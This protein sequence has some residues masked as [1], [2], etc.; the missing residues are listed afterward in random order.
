MYRL[1]KADA[2]TEKTEKTPRVGAPPPF[3]GGRL[4]VTDAAGKRTV[5][6]GVEIT[7]Y[8]EE[9]LEAR[10]C[11]ARERVASWAENARR[12]A[13]EGRERERDREPSRARPEK[14][15]EDDR[16]PRFSREATET[17]S[18]T[19]STVTETETEPAMR[20][21]NEPTASEPV[22][23]FE[24]KRLEAS[25]ADDEPPF[26]FVGGFVGYLGYETRAECGSFR[27]E[28]D[29]PTPDAAFFFADRFVVADHLTGDAFVAAL[30]DDPSAALRAHVEPLAENENRNGLASA[31]RAAAEGVLRV[32][33]DDAE[34]AARAWMAETE[35]AVL[36]CADIKNK[37]DTENM[38]L[39]RMLLRWS[40]VSRRMPSGARAIASAP[41][42]RRAGR[43]PPVRAARRP[44]RVRARHRRVA[45]FHRRGGDLRGVFDE[46]AGSRRTNEERGGGTKK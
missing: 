32:A 13:R 36:A 25:L 35:R 38:G 14:D 39:Q 37:N 3:T 5:S 21:T 30:T 31:A 46:P 8:L 20:T 2:K 22:E 9:A 24:R 16:S 12:R 17:E 26:D 27:S 7:A 44:R 10:R 41:S 40:R 33:A 11:G 28:N 6:E 43:P 23:D 34:A 29:A 4:E 18:V 19:E 45:G 1:P 42:P 15:S